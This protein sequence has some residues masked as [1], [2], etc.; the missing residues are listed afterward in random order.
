MVMVIIHRIQLYKS[1][2]VPGCRLVNKG[3]IT[4]AHG[5]RLFNKSI[6]GWWELLSQV[7]PIYYASHSA[8]WLLVRLS[9]V[10]VMY[11]GIFDDAS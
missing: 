4:V 10:D 2:E 8:I 5:I 11:F 3:K 6:Q 7:E 1:G 9:R